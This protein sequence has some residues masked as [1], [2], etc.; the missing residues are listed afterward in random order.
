MGNMMGEKQNGN[1]SFVN[2]TFFGGFP[3]K[4]ER[5]KD[6]SCSLLFFLYRIRQTDSYFLSSS[7]DKFMIFHLAMKSVLHLMEKHQLFAID[8]EGFC[9][10]FVIFFCL[11]FSSLVMNLMASCAPFQSNNQNYCFKYSILHL[12]LWGAH[13]NL[14]PIWTKFKMRTQNI[15]HKFWWYCKMCSKYIWH[16]ELRE[17]NQKK[18]TR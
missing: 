9:L 8:T 10:F 1:H 14:P 16:K 4:R 3:W 11:F 12:H 18:H 13:S 2:K 7:T 17:A 15:E 5:K 6:H